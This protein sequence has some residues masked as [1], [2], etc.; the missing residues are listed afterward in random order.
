MSRDKVAGIIA[1]ARRHQFCFFGSIWLDA[2][3]VSFD[4]YLVFL[5]YF[6]WFS[7]LL[8]SLSLTFVWAGYSRNGS[9]GNPL[10]PWPES[11]RWRSG[12]CGLVI[13][14]IER[15]LEYRERYR[16]WTFSQR[17]LPFPTSAGP[18]TDTPSDSDELGAY[19]LTGQELPVQ[20]YR[21]QRHSIWQQFEFNPHCVL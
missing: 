15:P 10:N 14:Y 17:P 20:N 18:V 8:L 11:A 3:S 21:L 13:L 1:R 6:L 4:L 9:I 2:E 19:C 12:Q 16:F 7:S 5:S